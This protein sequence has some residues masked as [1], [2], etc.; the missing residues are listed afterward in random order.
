MSEEDDNKFLYNPSCQALI[1]SL[2]T[3]LL[4]IDLFLKVFNISFASYL[5][6]TG[7]APAEPLELPLKYMDRS[8]WLKD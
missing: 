2:H 8:E 5:A 3:N 4:E 6:Q 7:G 1:T